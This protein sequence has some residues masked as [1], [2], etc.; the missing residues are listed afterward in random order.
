MRRS[1]SCSRTRSNTRAPA[2]RSSPIDLRAVASPTELT[3]TN[4]PSWTSTISARNSAT[5]RVCRLPIDIWIE[6]NA[7]VERAERPHVPSL[8][9][10]TAKAAALLTRSTS[11]VVTAPQ[12][13]ASAGRPGHRSPSDRGKKA[14]AGTKSRPWRSP[15]QVLCPGDKR[16]VTRAC[17]A[18]SSTT[19]STARCFRGAR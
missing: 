12:K 6:T 14:L 2:T 7:R 16:A 17:Y 19:A 3:R 13:P 10:Y 11:I 9:H 18:L 8:R 4:T 15:K 1:S 5:M